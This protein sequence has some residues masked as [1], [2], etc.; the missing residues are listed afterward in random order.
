MIERLARLEASP[1][2]RELEDIESAQKSTSEK[3][4]NIEHRLSKIEET[5]S[6]LWSKITFVVDLIVKFGY[7]IFVAWVLW[8]LGFQSPHSH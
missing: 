3:V 8:K 5:N 1:I 2:V 7:A 6:S 4:V